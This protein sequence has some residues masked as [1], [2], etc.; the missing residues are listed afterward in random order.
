M[1][2]R[3]M[4]HYPQMIVLFAVSTAAFALVSLFC[5]DFTLIPGYSSVRPVN[6]LPVTLGLLFGPA[7]AFGCAAGNVIGDVCRHELNWASIGGAVGNFLFAWIPYRLWYVREYRVGRVLPNIFSWQRLGAFC[8]LSALG[9][10]VCALVVSLS[11][12]LVSGDPFWDT[13]GLILGNNLL[14]AYVVGLPLF[15]VLPILVNAIGAYWRT[16]MRRSWE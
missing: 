13:F 3:R 8:L 7:G 4:W 15:A 12:V 9:A 11:I 1:E 16:I 6:G 2:L 14:G 5:S 10:A